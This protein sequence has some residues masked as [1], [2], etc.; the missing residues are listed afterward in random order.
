MGVRALLGSTLTVGFGG[1]RVTRVAAAR[2]Q[3]LLHPNPWIGVCRAS[4]DASGSQSLRDAF[5]IAPPPELLDDAFFASMDRALEAGS[6]EI[7]ATTSTHPAHGQLPSSIK[8][9]RRA[10]ESA[11]CAIKRAFASMVYMINA[12]HSH[13]LQIRQVMFAE[14]WDVQEV[15]LLVH[16]EMHSSFVWLFQRVF[17]CTP[18]LMLSVMILL[19]N[20]TVF[21]MGENL[22]LVT[23]TTPPAISHF[24]NRHSLD[25]PKTSLPQQRSFQAGPPASLGPSPRAGS[26]GNFRFPSSRTAQ[27]FDDDSWLTG[28]MKEQVQLAREISTRSLSAPQ[29]EADNYGCYDRTDLD[30]QLA[31]ARDPCSPV[32]LANYAQFLFVVRRNHDRAEEY[33][34]RAMRADPRD[35]TILDRFASFLW[36]GRGDRSAAERVYKAAVAAEPD[37]SYSVGSYA[38]FLWHDGDGDNNTTVA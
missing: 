25:N 29:V 5:R 4:A 13:A 7:F 38:H 10:R 36:L 21:S 33:F 32:L 27:G 20:F 17:A 31:I 9:L 14:T 37:S 16:K 1:P 8:K 22:A 30:Y 24:L 15:M 11:R 26:G 12:V 23:D 2:K 35:A 3:I 28:A 6:R 19:A 34:H 18:K